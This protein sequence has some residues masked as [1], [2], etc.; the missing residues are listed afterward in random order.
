MPPPPDDDL[1]TPALCQRHHR[2]RGPDSPIV[3]WRREP[4]ATMLGPIS[5]ARFAANSGPECDGEVP[6]NERVRL[7]ATDEDFRKLRA[8][9]VSR[10]VAPDAPINRLI[11]LFSKPRFTDERN[12]GGLSVFSERTT[13]RPTYLPLHGI[14]KQ[15]PCRLVRRR[16]GG[17][18]EAKNL[19]SICTCRK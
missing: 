1:D 11:E 3:R 7:V 12:G 14:P 16:P 10:G 6:R 9:M 4:K 5:G 18:H 19:F 15:T 2:G 8:E 17:A 13:A